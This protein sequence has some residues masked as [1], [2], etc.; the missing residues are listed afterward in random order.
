MSKLCLLMRADDRS[1]IS[2]ETVVSL[3]PARFS[4]GFEIVVVERGR[5]R[6][7]VGASDHLRIIRQPQVGFDQPIIGMPDRTS[8]EVVFLDDYRNCHH[9]EDIDRLEAQIAATAT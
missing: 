9:P 6:A 2:P 7:S 3:L 4:D 1:T 8:A 5:C